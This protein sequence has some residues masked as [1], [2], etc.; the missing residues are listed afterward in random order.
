ML[1]DQFVGLEDIQ[2]VLTLWDKIYLQILMKVMPNYKLM[3]WHIIL[4]F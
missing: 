2:T 3:S 4:D 1:L